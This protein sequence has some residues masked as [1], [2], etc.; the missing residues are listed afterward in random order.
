MRQC[1]ENRREQ[2]TGDKDVFTGKFIGSKHNKSPFI[3]RKVFYI[4][5]AE[6]RKSALE[7]LVIMHKNKCI[8]YGK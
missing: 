1:S 7:K 5:Y 4:V 2:K 6:V 8:L 3:S